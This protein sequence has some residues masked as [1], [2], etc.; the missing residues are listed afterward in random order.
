MKRSIAIVLTSLTALPVLANELPEGLRYVDPDPQI[1]STIRSQ[2]PERTAV[3]ASFLSPE[4]SPVL[5]LNQ[6]AKVWV[7]GW[8]EGAGYRNSIMALTY[9]DGAFDGLT[10]SDIDTNRGGTVS[11]DELN[12]VEGVSAAWLFPN[13][14]MQGKGGQL[15]PGATVDLNGGSALEANTNITFGLAQNAWTGSGINSGNQNGDRANFWGLDFL[16]PEAS[17][18][19]ALGTFEDNSRHV[20]MLFS[21]ESQNSVLMGFEDLVRPWGDNDFNDAVFTVYSTP[22]GAFAGSEISTAPV[23]GLGVMGFALVLMVAARNTRG[24][25]KLKLVRT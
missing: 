15:K 10:K 20:A 16:N 5:S 25:K 19:A 14:S 1:L 4:Y 7:T 17:S 11:M 22:E 21:D 6:T 23:P 3:N 8:D 24:R 18:D 2:L 13:F 9:G 12:A